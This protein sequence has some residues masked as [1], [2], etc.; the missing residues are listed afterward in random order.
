MTGAKYWVLKGNDL[1]SRAK[2]ELKK[3]VAALDNWYLYTFSD[4]QTE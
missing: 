2:C 1:D 3:V 4:Y